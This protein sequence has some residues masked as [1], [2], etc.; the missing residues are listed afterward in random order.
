MTMIYHED[1]GDLAYL[2]GKPVAVLGYGSLGRSIALN[3][4]DSGVQVFVGVRTAESAETARADG[5]APLA[6][7]AA[8]QAAPI[9]FM[10]L[11]DEVMP[12]VYLEQVSPHLRKGSTLVFASGY[13][14][15]F[16]YIEA[17]PFVD[18]GMI[19]PRTFGLAVR[20][21]VLS[22]EGFLSFVSVGQDASGNAWRTVLALARAAGTL[23]VG[24]LEVTMEQEAELDLFFQQ[25]ILPI[26]HNMIITAVNL[27]M[28]QGYPPEA[29]FSQLYLSGEFGDYLRRAEQKGLLPALALNPLTA[30]Y[31]TLNRLDRF[32]DLKLERLMEITLREI[33]DGA[34][35][36]EWRTEYGDGYPRLRK[37]MKHH[38]AADLWELERQ[39]LEMLGLNIE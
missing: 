33:R 17:P 24:A 23:K 4:R 1:S 37:L 11:P 12:T 15:A 34:F 25:A 16:G 28:Q 13:N 36:K 5:L 39:T 29:L 20:E 14:V 31:G 32:D 8:A 3:L 35:A 26:F 19:A 2:S 7:E 10:L 30:Q 38:S 22:G 21:R 27:L 9:L 6:I 18:V